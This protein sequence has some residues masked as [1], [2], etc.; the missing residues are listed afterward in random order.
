M[1]TVAIISLIFSL[2]YLT[3]GIIKGLFEFEGGNGMVDCL[4]SA[5]VL[6]FFS[7][8]LLEC[9]FKWVVLD[10]VSPVANLLLPNSFHPRRF[11]FHQNIPNN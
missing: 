11:P 10:P 9:L 2:E 1:I 7:M 5:V 4:L 6:A 8:Q 3:P